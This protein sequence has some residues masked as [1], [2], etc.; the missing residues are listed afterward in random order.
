MIQNHALA[1]VCLPPHRVGRGPAS[2]AEA[3]P[4]DRD[5]QLEASGNGRQC[6]GGTKGIGAV[7]HRR[8]RRSQTS[9]HTTPEEEVAH[10][11]FSA[12]N[13]L[14]GENVPGTSL[15]TTRMQ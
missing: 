6:R 4:D 15:E 12:R 10:E 13:E 1:A 2:A 8:R 3:T 14:V 5:G 7:E 9:K 11:R